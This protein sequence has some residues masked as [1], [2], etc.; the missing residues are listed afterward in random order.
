[1][2]HGQLTLGIHMRYVSVSKQYNFVLAKICSSPDN[3]GLVDS[4]DS[5]LPGLSLM[6]PAG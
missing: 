1:L 3:Q 6:L 2:T 5:L 4:N